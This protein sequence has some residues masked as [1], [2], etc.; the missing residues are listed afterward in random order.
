MRVRSR[1]TAIVNQGGI[2]SG[3]KRGACVPC[4]ALEFGGRIVRVRMR[5]DVEI[6]VESLRLT[7][8]KRFGLGR[9]LKEQQ[10][11]DI[12]L[13]GHLGN[14]IKVYYDEREGI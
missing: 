14:N 3:W 13:A 7:N 2:V 4:K 1:D 10:S 5:P 9:A 11:S 12:S 8:D 6:Q